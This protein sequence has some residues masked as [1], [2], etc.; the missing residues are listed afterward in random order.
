MRVLA[1][2]RRQT[3]QIGFVP[4]MGYLHDGHLSLIEAA[5]QHCETV[6]VSVFVNPTQFGPNEDLACYPRDIEGDAQK[7]AAAGA[8][9]LFAPQTDD[10]Y[11]G[12][13][14]V[15]VSL[16]TL[17]ERLCG[18]TRPN[19]FAGVCQVVLKLLN[20]V[21]C[22]VAVFGEKD[23]Q[24]LS[25]IRRMVADL[26]LDVEIIGAPIVREPDGLAMSSRNVYL[27]DHHR[28]LAPALFRTLQLLRRTVGDGERRMERLI[29]IGRERLAETPEIELEYLEIVEA[30]TLERVETI[31]NNVPLRALIAARL[32]QTRL[33]DNLAV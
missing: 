24:Q 19:H 28:T 29:D 18:R 14:S 3:G 9:I 8:H 22:N 16:P 7:I 33:I 5:R 26:F 30:N 21:S 12:G 13:E 10:I 4:T 20:I 25:V 27:S 31:E 17:S 23:Y 15:Q 1:R 32:G 11:D 2:Q 6:I